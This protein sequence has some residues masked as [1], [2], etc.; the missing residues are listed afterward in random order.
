VL[1]DQDGKTVKEQTLAFGK[2][3]LDWKLDDVEGWYPRNYGKQP[4]YQLELSLLDKV[5]RPSL[6]DEATLLTGQSGKEVASSTNRVAFRHAR[7]VQDPLEGQE[8]TSFLFEVNGVRVFCGG[9]NWI[10]AD[11]FLTEIEP[12]RYRKWVELLVSGLYRPVL[13]E[14]TLQVRGNQNMLRV[15][16]GGIYEDEVL[17]E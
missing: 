9:S 3:K 10:P 6:N 5:R 14:L 4:L 11:S 17:Y 13:D 7:V 15:W 12:E 1:R 8:G 2:D 16:G